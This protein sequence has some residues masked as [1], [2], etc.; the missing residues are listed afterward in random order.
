MKR[1]NT[2]RE[3]FAS[4]RALGEKGGSS[5]ITIAVFALMWGVVLAL[6]IYY[7]MNASGLF[8]LI[9]VISGIFLLICAWQAVNYFLCPGEPVKTDGTTLYFWSSRRWCELAVSEIDEVRTNSQLTHTFTTMRSLLDR[10]ALRIFDRR[11]NLFRVR[12]LAEPAEVKMLIDEMIG[13]NC[14]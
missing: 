5:L 2:D 8:T 9:I 14:T 7:Y 1:Q 3:K 11:N 10:G 12:F 6:S 13:K 4:A